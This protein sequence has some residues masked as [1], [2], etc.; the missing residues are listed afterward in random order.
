MSFITGMSSRPH[1]NQNIP[2]YSF[3]QRE[4]LGFVEYAPCEQPY[5]RIW[6][7][8][9]STYYSLNAK[10]V[11]TALIYQKPRSGTLIWPHTLP[12]HICLWIVYVCRYSK[13]I[14]HILALQKYTINILCLDVYFTLTRTHKWI[15][16]LFE[17]CFLVN[18]ISYLQDERNKL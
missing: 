17:G 13:Q 7:N 12:L 14:R 11:D 6:L 1:K 8:L 10:H 18:N 3:R 4:N 16:R 9:S 5:M 2:E 15:Y